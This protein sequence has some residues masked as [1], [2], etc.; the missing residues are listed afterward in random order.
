MTLAEVESILGGP[1][2]SK[3]PIIY[4]PPGTPR[5][6][7][8]WADGNAH[9]WVTFDKQ[10][11]VGGAQFFEDHPASLVRRWRHWIGW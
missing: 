6:S 2:W 1:A 4:P 9:L 10:D 3:H 5:V 11:R 8:H 7:R